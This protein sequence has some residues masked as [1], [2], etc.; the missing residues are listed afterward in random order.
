MSMEDMCKSETMMHCTLDKKSLD[1][2]DKPAVTMSNWCST[3]KDN[4]KART[5]AETDVASS[6]MYDHLYEVD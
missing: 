3:G 4:G 2:Q 1:N 6:T 5:R